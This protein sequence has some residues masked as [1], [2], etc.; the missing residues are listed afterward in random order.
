MSET[1]IAIKTLSANAPTPRL[2]VPGVEAFIR[3]MHPPAGNFDVVVMAPGG[4]NE[5]SGLG[6]ALKGSPIYT[7]Y[8]HVGDESEWTLEFCPP[9]VP[10]P[11]NTS[12]RVYVSDTA[13][14]SAPYPVTT[15]IPDSILRDP[16]STTLVFH[17]F[18]SAAGRFRDMVPDRIDA[19]AESVGSVLGD[20]QF[21][22]AS[23]SDVP[24]EVEVRLIVP[25]LS[26]SKRRRTSGP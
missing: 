2:D 17:G 12:Y 15:T 24:I 11:Q 10:Q 23:R 13:P 20:W 8:L 5:L 7:V 21:W 26:D 3:I 4:R 9:Y 25:A 14:V 22:P 19:T 18:L 6:G 1:G 16:R